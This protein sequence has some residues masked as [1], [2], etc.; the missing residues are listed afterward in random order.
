MFSMKYTKYL[1]V[2]SPNAGKYAP[3]ITSYLDFFHAV[4]HVI[5]DYFQ[6]WNDFLVNLKIT[7]TRVKF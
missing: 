5:R 3:E 1:S 7:V 2:F 6:K 4:L